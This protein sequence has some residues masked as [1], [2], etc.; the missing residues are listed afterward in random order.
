M[1]ISSVVSSCSGASATLLNIFWGRQR[2]PR[3]SQQVVN[4][5]AWLWRALRSAGLGVSG[6][7]G[8]SGGDSDA[9]E[10]ARESGGGDAGGE[11]EECEKGNAYSEGVVG[12]LEG[13]QE[14]N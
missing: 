6:S 10:E 1:S 5:L 9:S 13:E 8:L 4:R 11:D 14:R 3:V 12:E 2:P 7:R